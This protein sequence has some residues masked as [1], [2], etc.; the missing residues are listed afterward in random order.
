M[1][2]SHTQSCIDYVSYSVSE[3]SFFTPV[4]IISI[5]SPPLPN[6]NLGQPCGPSQSPFSCVDIKVLV[7][8]EVLV[9]SHMCSLGV[10]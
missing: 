3:F 6:I 8:L 5:F 4:Y 2:L 9:S 10:A 1:L 7:Y